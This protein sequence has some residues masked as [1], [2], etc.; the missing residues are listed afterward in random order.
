MDR[1]TSGQTFV[2]EEKY[3]KSILVK[4]TKTVCSKV[5]VLPEGRQN[6]TRLLQS[7]ATKFKSPLHLKFCI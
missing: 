1:Q 6:S 3:R 2:I 4:E 7:L 5:G